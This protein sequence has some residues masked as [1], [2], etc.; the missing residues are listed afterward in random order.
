MQ[1]SKVSREKL[2]IWNYKDDFGNLNKID[3][4]QI[5]SKKGWKK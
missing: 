5:L 3:F 4:W 2:I 1:G